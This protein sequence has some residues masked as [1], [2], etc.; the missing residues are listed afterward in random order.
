MEAMPEMTVSAP[1]AYNL[2]TYRPEVVADQ[3]KS[4][5]TKDGSRPRSRADVD[6][7]SGDGRR[8]SLSL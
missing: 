5:T 6:A 1:S 2:P 3:G 4:A 8:S 7:T